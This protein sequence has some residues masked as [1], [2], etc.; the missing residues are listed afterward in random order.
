MLIILIEFDIFYVNLLNFLFDFQF[1]D[2]FYLHINQNL[3]FYVNNYQ[4]V[5]YIIFILFVIVKIVVILL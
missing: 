1:I 2:D 3:I 4:V 5:F